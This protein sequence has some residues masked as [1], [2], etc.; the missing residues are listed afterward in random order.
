MAK[1]IENKALLT[2]LSLIM[3]KIGWVPK[4]GRNEFHKYD[5]AMEADIV[6]TIRTLLIENRVF[7]YPFVVEQKQTP[8]VEKGYMTEIMVRWRFVDLDSGES[9]SIDM[10]GSGYD[11]GDK[12][13]Y[14]AITGSEKYLLLKTF[15][16]PTGDDP[17]RD[18][19]GP[20]ASRNRPPANSPPK[21]VPRQPNAVSGPPKAVI[22]KSGKPLPVGKGIV[23]DVKEMLTKD[24]TRKYVQ[25]TQGGYKLSSFIDINR[26]FW[27][28]LL[29]EAKGE[30]CEFVVESK[31]SGGKT[32]HNIV[33]V[34]RIGATAWE[35]GYPIVQRE[36]G[37]DPE[38]PPPEYEED[39]PYG[40][41]LP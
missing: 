12:G 2:K 31:D 13:L 28:N 40:G 1:I 15:L 25:V 10:P 34:D 14:K 33:M 19:N 38:I 29:R 7:L 23:S 9:L 30:D 3:G 17:E 37:S 36:P 16:I 35:S 32:Y 41:R 4:A 20:P 8:C 18:E 26:I 11:N 24:K 39:D 22:P 27:E 6:A 21:L 5:Y